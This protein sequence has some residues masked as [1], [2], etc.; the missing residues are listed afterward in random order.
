MAWITLTHC[1]R[2]PSGK[3]EVWGVVAKESGAALGRVSWYAVWR[4][5]VFHPLPGT[6]YEQDCLRTIADFCEEETRKH[7]E[8]ASQPSQSRS[9]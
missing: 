6:L 4:R 5:Y 7:R 2:S 8:K 9:T 3:T 1:G